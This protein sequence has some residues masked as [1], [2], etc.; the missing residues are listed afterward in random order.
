MKNL[1]KIYTFDEGELK[2]KKNYRIAIL[3]LVQFV[4]LSTILVFNIISMNQ[5]SEKFDDI[6]YISEETKVL[7]IEENNKFSEA[8]LREYIITTNIRFPHIVLAQ[9]KLESGN[10]KSNIFLENNNLF[11][12]KV[13][14]K[15]PTLNKGE[16]HNHAYYDNWKESVL[17]YAFYQA[18]FLN[19]LKTEDAYYAYLSNNYAEDSDYVQKV[20]N[21]ADKIKKSF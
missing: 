8:R 20:R 17:D 13:A 3:I 2:Y 11:G 18:A 1:F 7:I 14:R 4:M 10:F 6:K 16:N 9:A 19:S 21:L 15:R 5:T 12:M